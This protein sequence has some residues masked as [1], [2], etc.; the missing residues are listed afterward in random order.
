MVKTM[1]KHVMEKHPDVAKRMEE[2]H[3]QA[4]RNGGE[5]RRPNGT[6][7]LMFDSPRISEAVTRSIL[8]NPPCHAI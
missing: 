5:K 6:P 2:M 7:R 4:P 3:N 8:Q 1:T